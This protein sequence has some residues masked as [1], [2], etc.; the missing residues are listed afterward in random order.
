MRSVPP[1]FWARAGAA[2]AVSA[3]AVPTANDNK[4]RIEQLLPGGA[5]L[6]GRVLLPRWFEAITTSATAKR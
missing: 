3:T 1:C 5:A 4:V 6:K 2:T